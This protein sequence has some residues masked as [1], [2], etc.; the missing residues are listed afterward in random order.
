MNIISTP[1]S[2][3]QRGILMKATWCS[4]SILTISCFTFISFHSF[5]LRMLSGEHLCSRKFPSV[6]ASLIIIINR[7]CILS[8]ELSLNY[9]LYLHQEASRCRALGGLKASET[10]LWDLALGQRD[11]PVS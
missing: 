2:V 4:Y 10:T 8:S 5:T 9:R 11:L 1:C 7:N 6:E 3:S